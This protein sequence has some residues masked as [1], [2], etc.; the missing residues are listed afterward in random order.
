MES[1]KSLV[2]FF[3]YMNSK[4]PNISFTYEIEENEQIPF[5][6][7]LIHRTNQKFET[8]IHRKS[9]FSGVYLHFHAFMPINYKLGLINSLLHRCYHLVSNYERFHNEVV[10]LQGIMVNNGYPVKVFDK[11]VNKFLMRLFTQKPA[12]LTAERKEIS[13]VLPYLG[14]KSL[15]LRTNL[16]R[17]IS[18]SFP[19]C[20][21]TV[22]FKSSNR[23][24]NYFKFK[25]RIPKSLLSGVIYRYLC[26]RCNSVYIGKTKRYYEKR[27]E[28]HL[29]ISAL[30]GKPM[31]TFQI[32][33]PMEHSK[34]CEGNNFT[35]D[36]FSVIGHQKQDFLLKIQESLTIYECK[37]GL[38]KQCESTPLYLFT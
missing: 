13:L 36:R 18:K 5:L 11:C 16:V 37:P 35:R 2:C 30:T 19:Y 20:K 17:L 31:K 29:S 28:E 32:W 8:S 14:A 24:G 1:Q 4:H 25:D 27:L 22:I 10:K 21:L 26:D 34:C 15:S 9:T 6:D 7:I 12:V 38:N 33:P 3:R 23:L